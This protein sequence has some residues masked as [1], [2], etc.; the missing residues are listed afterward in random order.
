[1][2]ALLPPLFDAA[3]PGV[4]VVVGQS[5]GPLECY[6]DSSSDM[7]GCAITEYT[8]T[9]GEALFGL[10]IG[11]ILLLSLYVAA[12]GDLV[13]PAVVTTLVGGGLIPLLPGSYQG[14]AIVIMFLGL[15]G[16]VFAVGVKYAT[17]GV[18]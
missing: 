8:G 2:T 6:V 7:L 15:I 16:S 9:V 1:M 12:D 13:V 17:Q 11:G 3:T 10:I 5:A 4:D 14:I 18:Y